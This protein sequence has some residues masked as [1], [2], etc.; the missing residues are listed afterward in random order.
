[1]CAS[2][3]ARRW[4][5]PD[6]DTE[7]PIP[8]ELPAPVQPL[9]VAEPP[10]GYTVGAKRAVFVTGL[11]YGIPYDQPNA[12]ILAELN[13]G[14]DAFP[15]DVPASAGDLAARLRGDRRR[16]LRA[17]F[18]GL[19]QRGVRVRDGRGGA[20]RRVRAIHLA[21]PTLARAH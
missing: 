14:R 3:C 7:A 15:R 17:R 12:R 16:T 10:A 21:R 1:M 18:L 19:A 11:E 6:E 8:V 2:A 4:Q 9:A 13:L 5:R 20:Q